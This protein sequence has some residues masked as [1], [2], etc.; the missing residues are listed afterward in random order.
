[1]RRLGD[2]VKQIV[3]PHR[4]HDAGTEISVRKRRQI[5]NDLF[6]IP[7]RIVPIAFGLAVKQGPGQCKDAEQADQYQCPAY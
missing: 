2:A 7:D 4:R 5:P 1:M 6:R 3:M